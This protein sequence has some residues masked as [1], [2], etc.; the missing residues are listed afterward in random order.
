M[1]KILAWLAGIVSF[2]AAIFGAGVFWNKSKRAKDDLK[3]Q[4]KAIK[5]DRED[6]RQYNE[7]IEKDN[8]D[9]RNNTYFK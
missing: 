4:Q 7:D 6:Q 3:G 9:I 8:A 5:K 1:S 2:V